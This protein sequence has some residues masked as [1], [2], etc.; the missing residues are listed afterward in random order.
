MA[1]DVIGFYFDGKKTFQLEQDERG[2]SYVILKDKGSSKGTRKRGK[3]QSQLGH[4]GHR[5]LR[6]D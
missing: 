6:K 4:R 2:K 3:D 1:R 5:D